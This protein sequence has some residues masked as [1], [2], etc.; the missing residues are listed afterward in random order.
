MRLLHSLIPW[1]AVSTATAGQ[2]GGP[3]PAEVVFEWAASKKAPAV[4]VGAECYVLP[5]SISEAGFECRFDNLKATVEGYGRSATVSYRIQSGK[6]VVPLGSVLKQIGGLGFWASDSSTFHVQ[7]AAKRITFKE[8]KLAVYGGLP[9]QAEARWLE[10]GPSVAILLTGVGLDE[11]ASV[12]LEDGAK[13]SQPAPGSLRIELPAPS[14]KVLKRLDLPGQCQ[15]LF[16]LDEVLV[17]A[18]Q[19]KPKPGAQAKEPAKRG[20]PAEQAKPVPPV[21]TGPPDTAVPP[22]PP[23]K[24]EGSKPAPSQGQESTPPIEQ[25]AGSSESE[26]VDREPP[27][28]IGAKPARLKGVQTAAESEVGVILKLGVVGELAQAPLF[29]RPEP[30]VVEAVLRGATAPPEVVLP[31]NRHVAALS[32]S[33]TDE[34]LV[35]RFELRQPMGA[36]ISYTSGEIHL[37]LAVQ[38]SGGSMSGKVIVVDA[39][40]GGSDTGA[41][42]PDKKV[43]EKAL[44]LS[45]A[46]KLAD[47]LAKEGA[48]VLMTRKTDVFIP[49]KERPEIAN[50]N[51]ADLFVSVH[52]NSN[53]NQNSSSGGITFYHAKDPVSNLLAECVQGAIARV[54]GLP[55]LGA[56]SDSR[57][58]KTGFAVLR[59]AKM[60]A[61]LI[62]M[63]FINHRTDRA[64]MT[65]EKFQS[66]VASAIVKGIKV[67]FGNE[68]E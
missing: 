64:K 17:P 67:Y 34:G 36:Q 25:G 41:R 6:K 61:I 32:A 33:V 21:V 53:E 46:Q 3:R 51:G 42:S 43:H 24:S 31:Q 5:Q 45:I 14:G 60:P 47:A 52:I 58:Y 49:L 8:G 9:F 23:A 66:D 35:L 39:G 57:I 27:K 29:R 19:S 11:D 30:N 40:H 15:L 26:A 62:E 12:V 56:W 55:S 50:R 16:D 2:V 54:S 7:S 65:T 59:Y 63:G 22:A 38:R 37:A 48:T 10:E 28:W 68:Q 20:P 44:A 13:L 1:M 18:P 4:R